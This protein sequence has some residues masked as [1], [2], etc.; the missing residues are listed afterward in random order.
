MNWITSN[1]VDLIQ[2]VLALLGAFSLIAKLTPTK[3]DDKIVDSVLRVIH[4][5]G[6]TKKE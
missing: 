2:A 5:F 1:W 4:T 3:S 6:L